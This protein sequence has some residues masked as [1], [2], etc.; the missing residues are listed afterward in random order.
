MW[1]GEDLAR[2]KRMAQ[3]RLDLVRPPEL[4]RQPVV[5]GDE[6]PALGSMAE[7]HLGHQEP[8]VMVESPSTHPH[9]GRRRRPERDSRAEGSL[10]DVEGFG[11]PP[12]A[13]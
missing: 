9:R 13:Q 6:D 7:R 2:R 8:G 4:R 12:L 10:V 3:R 11:H 5:D 1:R